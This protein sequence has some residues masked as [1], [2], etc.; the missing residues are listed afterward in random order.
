MREKINKNNYVPFL[1]YLSLQPFNQI[2]PVF[3]LEYEYGIDI[4]TKQ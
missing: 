4:L 3:E 2:S 1:F